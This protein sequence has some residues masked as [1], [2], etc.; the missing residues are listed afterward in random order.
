MGQPLASTAYQLF[1]YGSRTHEKARRGDPSLMHPK[2]RFLNQEGL[3]PGVVTIKRQTVLD[4][5][6]TEKDG[7]KR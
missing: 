2:A 5:I 4:T 1:V 3:P 6:Y 7:S